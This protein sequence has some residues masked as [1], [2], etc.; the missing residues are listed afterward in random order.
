MRI[1]TG[2]PS[3]MRYF[4]TL[5][6]GG[7][8]NYFGATAYMYQGYE[9]ALASGTIYFLPV[10]LGRKFL[11]KQY[12]IIISQFTTSGPM[13][14][15]FY[16]DSGDG[17]RRAKK[18]VEAY[19]NVTVS[20]TGFISKTLATPKM[21]HK[22][23]LY[24]AAVEMGSGVFSARCGWWGIAPL[25][26]FDYWSG[27]PTSKMAHGGYGTRTWQSTMEDP[28]AEGWGWT[29]QY[30]PLVFMREVNQNGT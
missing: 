10:F 24:W 30:I 1:N 7:Q 16:E 8:N 19:E 2:I 3:P 6:L 25:C 15:G 4:Q 26:A 23:K 22:G 28:Y 11:L 27:Y 14:I 29:K 21:L 12:G 5:S 18:L 9:L 13:H 17:T 20:A